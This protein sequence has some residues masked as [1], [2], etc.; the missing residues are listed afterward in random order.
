MK[1]LIVEDDSKIAIIIRPSTLLNVHNLLKQRKYRLLY[2][3]A[4]SKRKYWEGKGYRRGGTH[5]TAVF[6]VDPVEMRRLCFLPY[7]GIYMHSSSPGIHL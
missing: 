7:T 4:G 3:S 5:M 2:S 6:R 1:L